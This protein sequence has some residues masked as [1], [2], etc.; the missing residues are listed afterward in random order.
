MSIHDALSSTTLRWREVRGIRPGYDLTDGSDTFATVRAGEI[1]IGERLYRTEE[2][3]GS[4]TQLVDVATGARVGTI[5]PMAHGPAAIN[6]HTGRYRMSRRGV[7]PF[8]LEVTSDFGGPQV[9]RILHVRSTI[10]VRAGR[11]LAVAPASEV[12]LLVVL[13]GMRLL[14]LLAPTPAPVG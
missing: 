6:V 8:S 2:Q 11:E 9:L 14:D 3:K 12:G 5:R 13:S 4:Q 10:R 1:E 7:L